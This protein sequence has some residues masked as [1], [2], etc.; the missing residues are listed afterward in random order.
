MYDLFIFI[1]LWEEIKKLFW[2]NLNLSITLYNSFTY[3]FIHGEANNI[4]PEIKMYRA[5][6][7]GIIGIFQPLTLISVV[8]NGW[9]FPVYT[10]REEMRWLIIL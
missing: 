4:I 7:A 9:F 3:F 5:G 6:K 10:C 1:Y 8:R 2:K